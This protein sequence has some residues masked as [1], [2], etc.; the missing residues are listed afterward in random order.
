[1]ERHYRSIW[2]SDFHLGTPECQAESLLGFLRVTESEHLYLVGDIVD[3]L[4]LRRSWYWA[5][6]HNDVIQKLLR[7]ARKGTRV[8][9]IPGN[10]DEWLRAYGELHLGGV[11]LSG[12]LVHTTRDGRRMLVMHGDALDPHI[13]LSRWRQGL[14]DWGYDRLMSLNRYCNAVR[15]RFGH[16]RF[17]I[18]RAL[19]AWMS[20][21]AHYVNRFEQAAATEARRRNADGVICGHIHTPVIR[22][23][24]GIQYLNDGDWV[25]NC[26]AIVEHP[27]GRLDLV[28]WHEG[29]ESERKKT[30]A[31]VATLIGTGMRERF[32]HATETIRH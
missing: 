1:M 11:K 13:R 25:E 32:F 18:L 6:S 7:K 9:Y 21:A 27:D 19:K 4:R 8:T 28:R 10:H 29:F 20:E 31:N 5:Q 26:T 22:E 24:D 3:G 17:S 12:D 14:G 2:I 23:I 15:T 30:A 16:P